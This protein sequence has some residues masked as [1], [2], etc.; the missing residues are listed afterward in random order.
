[1]KSIVRCTVLAVHSKV[2][3]LYVVLR[4]AYGFAEN[5]LCSRM[6][7][8]TKGLSSQMKTEFVVISIN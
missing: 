5:M 2:T 8:R 6:S 3:E 1:M 4:L 7:I